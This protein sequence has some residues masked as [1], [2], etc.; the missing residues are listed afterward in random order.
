MTDYLANLNDS[1]REAAQHID[2]PMLVVAGAGSGKTRVVTSRIAHLINSGINDYNI[3][4]LTFTNKA[5]REMA[6]RVEG[7]VGPIRAL[8]TTF[9]SACAR[10]LRYDIESFDC[11]RN[12]NFTIY[13]ADDQGAVI[14]NCLKKLDEDPKK[15]N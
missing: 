6:Q 10:W 12:S 8:V 15:N 3:L 4:A 11:G 2:G 1:Q 13:D 5:A 7:M 14:K 9:H